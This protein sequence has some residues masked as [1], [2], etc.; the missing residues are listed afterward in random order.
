MKW[1]CMQHLHLIPVLT[2]SLLIGMRDYQTQALWTW[3]YYLILRM[4]KKS[5]LIHHLHLPLSVIS[6]PTITFAY[7]YMN[8]I[9]DFMSKE[10]SYS[11]YDIDDF[12]P[13]GEAEDCVISDY[14]L[15]SS[16]LSELS[17]SL[18]KKDVPSFFDYIN[19][20]EPNMEGGKSVGLCHPP[21]SSQESETLQSSSDASDDSLM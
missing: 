20:L 9:D 4:N 7:E 14:P 5:S 15:H 1:N 6:G 11:L 3:I 18:Y 17:Q 21:T 2:Q 16:R 13:V 8:D 19:D 10:A 12:K